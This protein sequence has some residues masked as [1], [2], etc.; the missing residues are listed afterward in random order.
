[1]LWE[2]VG[3]G[4]LD[5]NYPL[6]SPRNQARFSLLNLCVHPETNFLCQERLGFFWSLQKLGEISKLPTGVFK[7]P[8]SNSPRAVGVVVS[9]STVSPRGR[10]AWRRFREQMGQVSADRLKSQVLNKAGNHLSPPF[11]S[12]DLSKKGLFTMAQR[13]TVRINS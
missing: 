5:T 3:V 10:L 4:T 13:G 12:A 11:H 7:S 9:N 8:K 2:R 1:M 6:K